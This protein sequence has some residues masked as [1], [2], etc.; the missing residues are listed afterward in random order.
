MRID[1]NPN[2]GQVAQTPVKPA[3]QQISLRVDRPEAPPV[4]LHMVERG[5]E[6]HV[7]VR[8]ADAALQTSLRQDLGNLVRTLE[9]TGFKAETIV[10][11]APAR[12][13]PAPT[14]AAYFAGT[15]ANGDGASGQRDPQKRTPQQP[16]NKARRATAPKSAAAPPTD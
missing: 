12:S 10:P 13:T 5:G 2:V 6:V 15:S 11:T 4:D 3:A 9:H 7:T 14:A 16:R 8:T 1:P